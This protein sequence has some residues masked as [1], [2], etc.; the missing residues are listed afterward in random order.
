MSKV[1]KGLVG[2]MCFAMLL[3]TGCGSDGGISSSAYDKCYD[4][5]A[6]L[7]PIRDFL[8]LIQ[9]QVGE[10]QIRR[11]LIAK[12]VIAG[13]MLNCVVETTIVLNNEARKKFYEERIATSKAGQGETYTSVVN[14]KII[15]AL[16]ESGKA[17][18]EVWTKFNYTTIHTGLFVRITNND[19]DPNKVFQ[20]DDYNNANM[21]I[22]LVSIAK[23]SIT[24]DK[25]LKINTIAHLDTGKPDADF[26]KENPYGYVFYGRSY[27]TDQVNPTAKAIVDL[28]DILDKQTAVY[29]YNN[30]GNSYAPGADEDYH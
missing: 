13:Q 12:E 9:K 20:L 26:L 5:K 2:A 11:N 19:K 22:E 8:E 29:N 24:L 1:F 21:A 15:K 28:L 30:L 25:D 17:N 10:Q 4:E 6:Q 18:K 16:V 23:A 3:V 27:M 14:P 7:E